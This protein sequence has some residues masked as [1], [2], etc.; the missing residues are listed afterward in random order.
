MFTVVEKTAHA[1]AS[2]AGLLPI[3]VSHVWF[4]ALPLSSQFV[5]SGLEQGE[6]RVDSMFSKYLA[7]RE[8]RPAVLHSPKGISNTIQNQGMRSPTCKSRE[9][10]K[11]S[12]Y[13][14][15]PLGTKTSSKPIKD[16]G[17][18]TLVPLCEHCGP[19]QHLE[20]SEYCEHSLAPRWALDEAVFDPMFSPKTAIAGL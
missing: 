9:R 14:L 19:C 1:Q 6:G 5:V 15:E 10:P 18:R 7:R 4:R 17:V 20:H 2:L 16:R 3:V 13:S 12:N 8:S 11:A